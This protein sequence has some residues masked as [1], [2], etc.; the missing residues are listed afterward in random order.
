[1]KSLQVIPFLLILLTVLLED[2]LQAVGNLLGDIGGDLLHVTI[3][4]QIGA[5]DIQRN[6]GRVDHAMQQGEELRDDA[7]Y[8][9]S[10]EDLVA[11]EPVS[12]YAAGRY[13]T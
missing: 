11:V 2:A 10:D 1:M 3:A 5:G 7:L 4:L 6:V 13:S 8:L 9:V 12:C